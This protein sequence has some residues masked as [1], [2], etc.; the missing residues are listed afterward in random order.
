MN[1]VLAVILLIAMFLSC[2][3]DNTEHDE[4]LPTDNRQMTVAVV[5]PLSNTVTK[6]QFE[7]TAQWML[8]NFRKAQAADTVLIDLQ[9]EW[10]DEQAED[11]NALG[12]QLANRDDVKAIIGPFDNE[13]M[14]Q[15]ASHCQQNQKPLIA[16]TTTSEAILRRYAVSS[17]GPDDEVNKKAF[18]WPL[19]QSDIT[20]VETMLKHYVTQIGNYAELGHLNCAIFSPDDNYGKTFYDWV[21]F[22]GNTLNVDMLPN[23]LY[24]STDDL[25]D[26]LHH[27][28]DTVMS[29][30]NAS[31]TQAIDALLSN[32]FCVVEGLNQ[33]YEV[34]QARRDWMIRNDGGNPDDPAWDDKWQAIESVLRTWFV[35]SQLSEEGIASLGTDAVKKLQGCQGF[36]PYADLATGFESAYKERFSTTPSFAE[37]KL[38]DALLVVALA[39]YN[40]E[41]H[42]HLPS[43]N[44]NI[45]AIASQSNPSAMRQG[46]SAW[47]ADGMQ[48]I[49]QSI[50]SGQLP[51]SMLC[52]A[53]GGIA[54]DPMS[55][56]QLAE[57]TY[58]H[59]Q[60]AN[61]HLLH[62]TYYSAGG[63]QIV[64]TTV[65]WDIFYDEEMAANDFA[66]MVSDNDYG[67][68]YPPLSDQYA[69]LVQGSCGM[70]NYRHQS[71]VLSVY[72]LLRR[73]GFDDDHI[74][75]IVDAALA[76][77]PTN[78]EPGV[79]RG[80]TD[81]TDLLSGKDADKG[82]P[83]ALVDYDAATLTP[84]DI[85]NLLKD[86]PDGAN[87][88]FYWSGHGRNETHGGVNE[89]VWRET[90][91]GQGMTASML[92]QTIEQMAMRKMLII[93]EP[94]Y[95]EGVARAVR[96]Q[97][98]VLAM[99]G[100]SGDESSWAEYWNPYLGLYGTWMAD[101]FT[102]NVVKC[103]EQNPATTYRDLYL[104]C[105]RHTIGSHVKL[106]NAENFGN[107]YR[108]TLEEFIKYN[109]H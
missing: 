25:T 93:L 12:S 48:N 10:H 84:A 32:N 76:N 46:V 53:S 81:F 6:A 35:C 86:I 88:L 65:S 44:S 23:E 68:E 85:C 101:R 36:S 97:I 38:Y 95:A 98:G 45:F 11:I 42:A 41:F 13:L 56:T 1:K 87:I 80:G 33:L 83:A 18:F 64:D 26:R 104:Y 102:L 52:G 47:R 70:A 63:K 67:F 24:E 99:T 82:Y 9:I 73:G 30:M 31:P 16:P 19:C 21:P 17:A 92:Q 20:L 55:C 100:A 37:C 59:W 15:F 77:D 105:M 108:N 43:F 79:I 14:A 4:N 90:E 75:L 107:L 57:N 58:V 54:F 60:I 89:L 72:Q 5:A 94:C 78:N 7:R 8:D 109:Q 71:D 29:E 22:F 34:A 40:A 106:I 3:K 69:V 103:L 51:S 50:R 74:I 91:A 96:G 49:L 66:D 62:P 61:G 2:S 28:F 27:Y 39:A